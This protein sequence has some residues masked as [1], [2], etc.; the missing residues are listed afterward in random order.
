MDLFF[1]LTRGCKPLPHAISDSNIFVDAVPI[2]ENL[3]PNP[4]TP[5]VNATV[6]SS[7]LCAMPFALCQHH[8]QSD[9]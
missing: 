3:N 4:L 6:F 5:R 2:N 1:D 7:T 9:I 8:P